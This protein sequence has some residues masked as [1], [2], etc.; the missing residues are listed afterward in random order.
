MRVPAAC[1]LKNA[2]KITVSTAIAAP[3]AEVWNAVTPPSIVATGTASDGF[4]RTTT[5]TVDHCAGQQVSRH[6]WEAKDGSMVVAGD[7]R[8]R[9]HTALVV[10]SGD[11]AASVTFRRGAKA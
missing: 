1:P 7:T 2:A 5:A 10:R 4:A 6:A 8:V 9:N 3:I 11:R